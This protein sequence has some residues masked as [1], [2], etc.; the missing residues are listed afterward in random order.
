MING[1]GWIVVRILADDRAVDVVRRTAAA[2][3]QRGVSLTL[4]QRP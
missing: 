3:Q 4:R 1:Q 2:W